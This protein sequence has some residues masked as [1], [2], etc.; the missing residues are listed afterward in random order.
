MHS[1][2]TQEEGWSVCDGL[3][4]TQGMAGEL[5]EPAP[6]NSHSKELSCAQSSAL[7]WKPVRST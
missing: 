7:G 5:G 3:G 1:P 6:N 4:S 2:V